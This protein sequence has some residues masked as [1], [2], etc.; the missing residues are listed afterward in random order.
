[1][2]LRLCSQHNIY[3]FCNIIGRIADKEKL[4][5]CVK[6]NFR[7]SVI[8]D[9]TINLMAFNLYRHVSGIFSSEIEDCSIEELESKARDEIEHFKSYIAETK[10]KIAGFEMEE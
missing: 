2:N 1:M 4:D 9:I 5:I 8:R 10:L 3:L 7:G 6:L